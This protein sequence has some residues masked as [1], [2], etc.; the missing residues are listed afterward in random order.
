MRL[1]KAT[2]LTSH[3]KAVAIALT[4][5]QTVYS[6]YFVAMQQCKFTLSKPA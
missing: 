3:V 6:V 4:H 5:R 1:T 2:G